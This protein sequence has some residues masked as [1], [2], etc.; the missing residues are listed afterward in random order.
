VIDVGLLLAMIVAVAAPVLVSRRWPLRTVEPPASLL[1]VALGPALAGLAVGRLTAVALD[2]PRSL[3]SPADLL[4]IRSGVEL[5]PG[6]MAA[7]ALAAWSARRVGVAAIDRLADGA[8]F[9]LV[10]YAGYEVTCPFRGGC[11]GPEAPVGLRPPGLTTTM[12]PVGIL[13][14]V[15]VAVGA[16]VV[17]R[18]ADRGA[19]GGLIP[20]MA[21][22]VVASVRAVGSIW[23]PHVGS[24]PTRQHLTSA[25]VA[26]IAAVTLVGL[27]RLERRRGAGQAPPLRT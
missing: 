22:L 23:L 12:V 13:I 20:V 19:S 14:A 8:P 4:I 26:V 3:L 21:I 6:V 24:G 2:D 9:A 11:F 25:I 5:W 18:L 7:T 1:D 10:S 27:L 17:R 16:F 15:A